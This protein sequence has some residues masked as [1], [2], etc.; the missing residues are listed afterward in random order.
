MK[1]L[2]FRLNGSAVLESK[3]IIA[4][5]AAN[6]QS[7]RIEQIADQALFLALLAIVKMHDHDSHGCGQIE[8]GEEASEHGSGSGRQIADRGLFPEAPES[9]GDE[10]R[11]DTGFD[12]QNGAPEKRGK[13]NENLQQQIER[14]FFF[15]VVIQIQ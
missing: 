1:T 3:R 13:G 6:G 9:Q 7:S 15:G 11:A 4:N 10:Q 14:L 8:D 2:P 12:L 5:D